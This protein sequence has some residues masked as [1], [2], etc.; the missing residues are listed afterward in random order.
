MLFFCIPLVWAEQSLAQGPPAVY[1]YDPDPDGLETTTQGGRASFGIRIANVSFVPAGGLTVAI[2]SS[3]ANEVVFA[4]LNNSNL[5]GTVTLTFTTADFDTYQRVTLRGRSGSASTSDRTLSINVGATGLPPETHEIVNKYVSDAVF[6]MPPYIYSTNP[7]GTTTQT[8]GEHVFGIALSRFPG[9]DPATVTLVSSDPAEIVFAS[10]GTTLSVIQLVFDRSNYGMHQSVTLRGV[11]TGATG[12][13]TVPISV[14]GG[15]WP[16]RSFFR[17]VN[18]P[19]ALYVFDRLLSGFRTFGQG[20]KSTLGIRL[21]SDPSG[22]AEVTITIDTTDPDTT[23]PLVADNQVVALGASNM[24]SV[25]LTFNSGNYMSFQSVTVTEQATSEDAAAR[26]VDLTLTSTGIRQVV[27]SVR[28]ERAVSPM[29]FLGQPLY[30]HRDGGEDTISVRLTRFPVA[31]GDVTVTFTPTASEDEYIFPSGPGFTH[32]NGLGTQ[33]LTFDMANHATYQS[34]RIQAVTLATLALSNTGGMQASVGGFN[35]PE[36]VT[37][38]NARYR[39]PPYEFVGL[40]LL[41]EAASSGTIGIRP[42]SDPG[43]MVMVTVESQH[44]NVAE[45]SSAT[46]LTFSSSN[47]MDFQMITVRTRKAGEAFL[48]FTENANAVAVQVLVGVNLQIGARMALGAFDR[49]S[50]QL[51]LD[52][53][54]SRRA[55]VPAERFSIN[56]GGVNILEKVSQ[57]PVSAVQDDPWSIKGDLASGRENAADL[58]SDGAFVL[59]LSD[60]GPAQIEMWGAAGLHKFKGDPT[61]D[62]HKLNY[63]GETRAFHLGVDASYD[64]G[65]RLGL[66]IGASDSEADITGN[67]KLERDLLSVHPY[68]SWDQGDLSALMVA[69]FGKGDYTMTSSSTLADDVV[70]HGDASMLMLGG[71]LERTWDINDYDLKSSIG[72]QLTQSE[73]ERT[74]FSSGNVLK[75]V[76]AETWRMRASLEAG[77]DYA[78]DGGFSLRPRISASGRLDGGNAGRGGAVEAG[79]GL[80]AYWTSGLDAELEGRVQV[81][82]SS[83]R[84]H[85]FRG[86]ISYDR[87]H[88]R[89]GLQFSLKESLSMSKDED[90]SSELNSVLHA[91]TGYVRGHLFM[92]TPGVFETYLDLEAGNGDVHS[93][94]TLGFEF[95]AQEFKLGFEAQSRK[96]EAKIDF[97]F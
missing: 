67:L 11:L 1:D 72:G 74:H 86:R 6:Q 82:K 54:G 52:L 53:V 24:A 71:T 88:D 45:V 16:G 66:G 90:G 93:R 81:T 85:S 19:S 91:R 50:A 34:V 46:V 57:P 69:G 44:P 70:A 60:K 43:S 92:L 47:Y 48:L 61:L 36:A 73:L 75:E 56:V 17:A 62:G 12:S 20:S 13:Q 18:Q 22:T 59:P 33:E 79:A 25:T 58:L 78:M 40:P 95:A 23:G 83:L 94:P 49:N 9:S 42:I 35:M 27:V 5:G 68:I 26:N 29:E 84:E 89:R 21:G 80:S 28:K 7:G 96:T 64:R 39:P 10:G 63:E 31:G 41:L 3:D 65:L 32:Q 51:A 14:S 15:G 8:G 4:D 37:L 87:D 55:A 38:I 76:K 30:I 2:S 77:R 97:R